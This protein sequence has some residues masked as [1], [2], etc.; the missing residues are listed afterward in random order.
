MNLKMICEEKQKENRLS[1]IRHEFERFL[2]KNSDG[3]ILHAT[4]LGWS[5][6]WFNLVP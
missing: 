2:C 1:D 4:L 5:F 6:I 3:S